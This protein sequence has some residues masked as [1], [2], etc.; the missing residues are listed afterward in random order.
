MSYLKSVDWLKNLMDQK[1]VHFVIV[2]VRFSLGDPTA[3]RKSYL[4]GHIPGAVYLDLDQ[5]LSS[6]VGKH[7]GRHPLP[8]IDELCIKLGEIGIDQSTYVIIYDDQDGMFAARL[9]W[10]LRYLGHTNIYIL[11]GGYSKWVQAG[12]DQTTDIPQYEKRTFHPALLL[13]EI[14]YMKDV[15][16]RLHHE[17]VLLIDSRERTR[18]L[19]EEEPIDKKAGH[20]PGAINYFWKE[21]ITDS[22]EWK[23]K[24]DLQKHFSS[25]PKEKEIIVYCGSGV[26]ACPNILA[27]HEAGYQNVKLYAGSW[28][29]WISYPENAIALE[30]E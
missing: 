16:N 21:V 19:G 6:T 25:V 10:Q 15:K 14:M 24:N 3:G 30:E 7:G 23:T 26:S 22:G 1:V 17:N 12:L 13:D 28:S 20:I 5:D 9:W 4:N 8:N 11:N 27:L 18:Y 29:D 2:D